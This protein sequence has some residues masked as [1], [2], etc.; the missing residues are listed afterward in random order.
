MEVGLLIAIGFIYLQV[1][2]ITSFAILFSAFSTPTLSAIFTLSIFVI[3]SLSRDIRL[4]GKNAES[5]M[6]RM[7]TEGVYLLLPNLDNFNFKSQV[8]HDVA[9]PPEQYAF[10]AAYGLVYGALVL[11]LATFIFSR[12]DFK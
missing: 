6:V 11:A 10:S 9:I 12:R 5:E 1:L 7:V 8:V 2:V 4:F 3:G